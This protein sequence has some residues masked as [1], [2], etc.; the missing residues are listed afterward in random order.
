MER[1]P[2]VSGGRNAFLLRL[3]Y[4]LSRLPRPPLELPCCNIAAVIRPSDGCTS[5][6]PWPWKDIWI[7]SPEPRPIRFF[8]LKSVRMPVVTPED[9]VIA[10]WASANVGAD[11]TLSST[12]GPSERIAT[13]PVPCSAR[14]N[15]PPPIIDDAPA[16]RLMSQSIPES[17]ASRFGP[18]TVM[19]SFSR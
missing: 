19:K 3:F 12:G 13:Q 14:L 17:N 7:D 8:I 2:Q 11:A 9:Q 1:R 15:R 6:Q 18:L 4:P 5:T 10:A 16:T